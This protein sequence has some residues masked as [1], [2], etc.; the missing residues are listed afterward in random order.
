MNL[1]EF[2]RKLMTEPGDTSA[3]MRAARAQ[4]GEFA[5]AAAESD[6]FEALLADAFKVK[7]PEGL[8]EQIILHQSMHTESPTRWRRPGW[9]AVA[10]AVT[11]AVALTSF[12]LIQQQPHES[13]SE[14]LIAHWSHDGP[15]IMLLASRSEMIIP[16]EAERIFSSLGLA[17]D[18]QF[19]T[20]LRFVKYCPTPDGRGAHLVL[21]TDQGPITMFYMPN[22]R[23]AD[24]EQT[25]ELPDGMQALAVNVE[26]GSLA[27][28]AAPDVDKPAMA[29]QIASQMS[30]PQSV[31][32]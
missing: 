20:S 10:A 3:E 26:R 25:V 27:L 11:L 21:D 24:G 2:K 29:R 8:A 31:T 23:V 16:N 13:L 4:D 7:P 6:R 22:T 17:V 32:L 5:E 28:V 12:N 1:L 14:H 19:M 18:D 30:F 15:E 9:F